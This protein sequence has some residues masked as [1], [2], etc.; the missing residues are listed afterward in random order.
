[1][2]HD[3]ERAECSQDESNRKASPD[4]LRDSLL[5]AKVSHLDH[6]CPLGQQSIG[7]KQPAKMSHMPGTSRFH[8]A[9]MQAGSGVA[10]ATTIARISGAL[11]FAP[12][13]NAPPAHATQPHEPPRTPSPNTG[14][15]IALF[16]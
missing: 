14:A 1:M 10:S 13:V 9:T 8:R 11:S 7:K 4:G 12:I 16:D 2:S 5:I 15:L 6:V 3:R